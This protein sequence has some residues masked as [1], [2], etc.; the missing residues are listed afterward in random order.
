MNFLAL[1]YLLCSLVCL[2]LASFVLGR[3]EKS[4]ARDAF[5]LQVSFAFIWQM[6]T[7]FVMTA[8]NIHLATL[9]SRIA[10]SGCIYLSIASYHF[11]VNFLNL[12]NQ[13]KFI[14]ASYIIGT[15][16]FIPLL[17]SDLLLENVF[18]YSWGYWFKAGE[19]HPFFLVYFA[20]C[21]LAAF[22]NLGI[23]SFKITD[24]VERN[25]CRLLFW[26]YLICYL[27]IIDFFPDYGYDIVPLGFLFVNIFLFLVWFV[28]KLYDFFY[29]WKKVV[30]FSNPA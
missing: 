17:F 10:Y 7:Y 8:P 30:Q 20:V 23:Y 21:A 1:A 16:I 6:G 28:I 11:V 29:M 26:A 27:S 15:I 5:L 14:K 9:F 4:P 25:K 19:F 24:K 12:T 2:I 13:Q 3:H 22:I 18:L